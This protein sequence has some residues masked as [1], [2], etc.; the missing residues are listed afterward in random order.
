MKKS[1]LAVITIVLL[2]T[3]GCSQNNSKK[4]ETNN[5]KTMKT[6]VCY[7]S[8]SGVTKAVATRLANI[9]N[10]DLY[11]I[12]PETPYTA[13][14]LDWTNKQSRSSVEMNDLSSRPA[15]IKDLENAEQY[16]VVYVGFPIWW[17]TAPTIINTFIE[18]YGFKGKTLIPFATSGSSDIKK[19]CNDLKSAYP[20]INW[21]DGKLL[22]RVSDE[23]LKQ[24]VEGI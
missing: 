1:L 17:Y 2:A 21:K 8:C 18:T 24:W 20:E 3:S 16:D 14:D 10:A 7:F 4:S 15:F 11:E 9:A 23:E 5:D 13:A 12:K 19:S 22:N 6:L